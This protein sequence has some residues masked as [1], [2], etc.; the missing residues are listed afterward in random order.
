[1]MSN[2]VPN[3]NQETLNYF[4]QNQKVEKEEVEIYLDCLEFDNTVNLV[5]N[6]LNGFMSLVDLKREYYTTMDEIHV[7]GKY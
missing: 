7:K 3:V 1:M 2:N 4:L 5:K 6:L